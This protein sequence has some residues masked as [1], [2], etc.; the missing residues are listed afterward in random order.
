MKSKHAV[1][2]GGG[3]GG[4]AVA[5]RLAARRW[6]VT[7]CEQGASFGGKMNHWSERGFRFDTGPSLITMPWVFAELF[8]AAGAAIEDH[9]EIV[10]VHPICKYV[11]PDGAQFTYSALMPEWLETVRNL[12]ARDVD[13]FL[14]FMN[15]GARIYEVSKDIFLRRRPLDWPRAADAKVLRHLP[16]R[17]GWGNYHKTVAAHFRSPRL[18]QLYDRY[19][20]Y[21]GSSPYQSPATLAIIP[22]IEYAF[23]GW[24]V[25]G[26]LYRIVESL[27][28]LARERGVEL[29]LNSRVESI[30]CDGKRVIGVRESDNDLIEA[31]VVVMNGDTSQV[32]QMIG[33][34]VSRIVDDNVSRIV[35][36]NPTSPTSPI[37][38]ASPISPIKPTTPTTLSLPYRER[39]MSGFVML[40]GVKR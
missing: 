25:K 4:L 20:T 28:E 30:E 8:T 27:V 1:I 36:V 16:W 19:P 32:P 38:P 11:Y 22:F 35:G 10:P 2:I 18:R 17:Y 9:L 3:L 40:L 33:D 7:V 26:G 29:L 37:S 12:D 5:L 14:R 15:L 24:Y 39:S 34:N 21:V 6:S 31:D 23:G 13:G